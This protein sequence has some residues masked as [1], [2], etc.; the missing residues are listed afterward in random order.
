MNLQFCR[1]KG[2]Q[3][4]R[5]HNKAAAPKGTIPSCYAIGFLVTTKFSVLREGGGKDAR[6][7]REGWLGI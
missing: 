7:R 4:R 5:T 3:Q 2:K 1:K 6:I